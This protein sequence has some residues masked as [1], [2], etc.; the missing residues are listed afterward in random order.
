MLTLYQFGNSV[1]AQKVRITLAE[2]DLD[3]EPVEVNLFK[4]EQYNPEYLKLNPKGVVPTLVHDGK[5]VIESTLIC[6]YLDDVFPDPKLTPDDPYERSQMR[7]WSKMVDEGLHEGTTEISF[8]AMFRERMKKLTP[9]QREL[10]FQNIGDPRRRARFTST[11]NDGVESPFVLNAIAAFEKAFKTLEETLSDGRDWI[12]GD[13]YTLADINIM[14]YAARMTY[15]GLIDAWTA[16]RPH[17]QAWWKR[18]SALPSFKAGLSDL[19]SDEEMSE[20]AKHGPSIL[21]RVRELRA[22]HVAQLTH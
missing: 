13:K 16:D 18:A 6:E 20:M 11:Y 5:P 12:F 2:K 1:C 9:E 22:E 3:W 7:L 10:R 19:L 21:D 8:S 15:L 17:V 14:P 4:S